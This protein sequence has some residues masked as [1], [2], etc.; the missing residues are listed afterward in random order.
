MKTLTLVCN[1]VL[2]GFI[3]LS[4]LTEGLPDETNLFIMILLVLTVTIMNIVMISGSNLHPDWFI[5]KRK[6]RSPVKERVK[7]RSAYM[8]IKIFAAILNVIMA[9]YVYWTIRNE[10]PRSSGFIFNI[11]LAFII[12]T[13][14]LSIL[15]IFV[16]RWNRFE[17]LKRTIILTG[18]SLAV[19]FFGSIITMQI[20]IGQGIK[21][22]ISI[23][24][25]EYPG[26]AEDA[27]LAYLA[28]PTKP[29]RERTNVAIWTLG[30]IRSRKALPVLKE[31]YKN[32][33]E[34]NIC[35]HNT[36]LCQ[37]EI[38]KAIISIE[39]N[40][41]GAKEKNWFGSWARLNK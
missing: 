24:K 7:S 37:Y 13:P 22:N 33:P 14:L 21:K 36:E 4:I 20:L 10:Y 9:G 15:R 3:G 28:D 25:K 12:L 2:L 16:G 31:L 8:V 38:H 1:F 6:G 17:G 30:Q 11:I 29:P 39:N 26:K 40:W 32:D 41:L 35:R 23:A 19:L 18:M 5:L 34:G 27:L